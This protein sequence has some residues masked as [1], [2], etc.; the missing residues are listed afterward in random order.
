MHP[1]LFSFGPFQVYAYGALMALGFAAGLVNWIVLGRKTGRSVSFCSDLML[2][3]MLSG[4]LG[5]RLAYVLEHIPVFVANP[6]RLVR[7]D[8]GGLVFY[9]GFVGSAVAVLFFARRHRVALGPLVD[10]TLTAVPL[11]H[12]LG[13]IGC[14]L[15]SCCYGAVCLAERAGVVFPRH[16]HPWLS[17]VRAG[18]LG[19]DAA[20]SLP[21]YPVQLYEAGY[22]LVVYALVLSVFLRSR[23]DGTVTGVY[24]VLYAC[25]RF[26]LELFRGDTVDRA[27]MGFFS[28]GQIASIPLLLVGIVLLGIARRRDERGHDER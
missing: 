25:G 15:N 1:H 14:F 10:F 7:L 17:H 6:A 21:V 16:S 4:V 26:L 3:V 20:A 27:A 8:E 2:W 5:A 28:A 12:A 23:R 24:L 11:A 22:N 18:L 19:P 13:R 9:G